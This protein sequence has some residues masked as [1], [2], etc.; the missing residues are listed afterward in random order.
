MKRDFLILEGDQMSGDDWT[1]EINSNLVPEY[2]WIT[3]WKTATVV[4][5]HQ[6]IGR[7][8]VLVL[9]RFIVGLGVGCAIERHH[10]VRLRDCR[11][12]SPQM[13]AIF[14]WFCGHYSDVTQPQLNGDQVKETGTAARSTL[15]AEAKAKKRLA[16]AAKKLLKGG[17]S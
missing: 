17:V 16:A 15:A 3:D 10:A 4:V 11:Q 2:W 14:E 12:R 13:K 8:N 1:D 6:R 5:H 7:E 9:E